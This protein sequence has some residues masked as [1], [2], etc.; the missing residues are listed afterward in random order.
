MDNFIE[1]APFVLSI[2]VFYSIV[3]LT[4][5]TSFSELEQYGHR[6]EAAAGSSLCSICRNSASNPIQRWIT[7]KARR[8]E[9]PDDED[10]AD[11]PNRNATFTK[12]REDNREK[13]FFEAYLG[14]A[15]NHCACWSNPAAFA[16]RVFGGKLQYS[17]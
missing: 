16:R 10:D 17:D 2:G 14:Q 11:C 1:L 8:K 7:E 9:A 4:F 12:N 6:H 5:A 15:R 13:N 3:F